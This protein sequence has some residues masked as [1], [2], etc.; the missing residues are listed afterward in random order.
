MSTTGASILWFALVLLGGI[1]LVLFATLLIQRGVASLAAG[2]LQRRT[3]A[4]TPVVLAAIDD[5]AADS[6]LARR[7]RPSDRGVLRHILLRLALDLRGDEREAVRRLYRDF[8]L[9]DSEV[10]WLRSWLARRRAAAAAH[11]GI[12]RYPESLPAL[13]QAMTDPD[14]MVRLAAVRAVGQVGGPEAMATLIPTLGDPRGMVAR[15]ALD[16]LAERGTQAVDQI[17]TYAQSTD[18]R[19]GRRA[20]IELLGLLRSPQAVPYLLERIW[21]P[22]PDERLPAVRAAAAIGDPRF[23]EAFHILL[24]DAQWEVRLQAAKGLGMLGSTAS[25]PLLRRAFGD[26][27]WWVR[28]RAGVALAEIGGPDALE[29][30]LLDPDPH[31]QELARYLLAHGTARPVIP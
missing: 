3:S 5:A 14:P 2:H 30:A 18:N 8:G 9:R 11:L 28:F 23:L 13:I 16:I 22:H 27:H 15:R 6:E 19:D 7:M 12:L 21:S 10:R 25:I 20:A 31:V 17:L 1:L 24:A 26:R 4:L 29:E